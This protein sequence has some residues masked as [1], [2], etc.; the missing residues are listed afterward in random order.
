MTVKEWLRKTYDPDEFILVRNRATCADGFT[1][2]IQASR[3]HYCTPRRDL[4]DCEYTHL[5]LGYPSE[6]EDLLDGYR[7]GTVYPYV[8]IEVAGQVV[9]KHGGIVWR[10]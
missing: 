8:P 4:K 5:E 6:H 7:E 9:E 3:G 10:D 1:I 2:S